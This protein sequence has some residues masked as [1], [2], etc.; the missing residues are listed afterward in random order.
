LC[1]ALGRCTASAEPTLRPTLSLARVRCRAY[2][3]TELPPRS[4]HSVQI[5][6]CAVSIANVKTKTLWQTSPLPYFTISQKPTGIFELPTARLLSECSAAKLSR[7][8]W[9]VNPAKGTCSYKKD[10]T[11]ENITKRKSETAGGKLRSRQSTFRH[12]PYAQ[13]PVVIRSSAV[14]LPVKTKYSAQTLADPYT[15][16]NA[17]SRRIPGFA[18]CR[19]TDLSQITMG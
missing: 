3:S 6:C 11:V 2:S 19:A 9:R 12:R 14:L 1:A 4:L 16:E 17:L 13:I 15:K 7:L 8:M 5:L 18:M 10:D